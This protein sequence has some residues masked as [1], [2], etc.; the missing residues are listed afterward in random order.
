MRRAVASILAGSLVLGC[1]SVEGARLH[2]SGARAL[3]RGDTAR[4]VADLEAAAER[5]PNVSE[6]RN[7]LG[8][9]YAA[10]GRREDAIREFRSAVALDCGNALAA[11][12]LRRALAAEGGAP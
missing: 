4:A 10:A 5:L 8:V 12:N 9:A 11:R 1:A 7:R 3:E 2:E 6:V